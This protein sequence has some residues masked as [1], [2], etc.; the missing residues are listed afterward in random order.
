[1]LSWRIETPGPGMETP[2]L[3]QL[4]ELS[5]PQD[6][7]L[8]PTWVPRLHDTFAQVGLAVVETDVRDASPALAL[9][10]H[11]C[12]L[13]IHGML[14]Q[15]TQNNEVATR[16]KELMPRVLDETRRGAHFAFTRWTV[17]GQKPV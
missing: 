16:L 6:P 14:A 5:Q 15:T 10:Y 1:M 8:S 13:Q 17:V 7:R 12:A 3:A 9:A 4:M 2:A 11:D